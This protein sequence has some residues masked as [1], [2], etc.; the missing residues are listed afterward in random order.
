MLMCFAGPPV[1]VAQKHLEEQT[2]FPP[3]MKVSLWRKPKFAWVMLT[4]ALGWSAFS[5][6]MLFASE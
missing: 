3:L 2:D 5:S 1:A 6:Y 4:G